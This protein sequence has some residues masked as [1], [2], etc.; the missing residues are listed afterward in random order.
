MTTPTHR[1][2]KVKMDMTITAAD[3][4]SRIQRRYFA[5]HDPAFCD[6]TKCPICVEKVALV[7]SMIRRSA[8]TRVK[9]RVSSGAMRRVTHRETRFEVIPGTLFAPQYYG[10][11]W[12]LGEGL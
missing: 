3:L 7:Q 4:T 9:Y 8:P 5:P 1:P 11:P 2:R 10:I 12:T 6:L